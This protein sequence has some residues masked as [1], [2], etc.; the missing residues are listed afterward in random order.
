M[1][2]DSSIISGTSGATFSDDC[3]YRYRLWRRW[4]EGDTLG[5]VLLNP[6][7]ADETESDPT[8]TRCI[9]F[10]KRFGYG[11]LVIVNLFGYQTSEPSEMKQRED[12]VGP[13][14]D[15]H[16]RTVCEAVDT[17]IAGWGNSGEHE[18]RAITV[19]QMLE[20][21]L[22]ALAVNQTGHPRHPLYVSKDTEPVPY[23]AEELL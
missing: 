13:E 5:W 21:K 23:S 3:A 22:H 18:E 2:E 17:I 4:D 6:S 12:P 16:L 14:N 10:S 19:A 15:E 20:G 11:S 9:D 1:T 8:L 7:T